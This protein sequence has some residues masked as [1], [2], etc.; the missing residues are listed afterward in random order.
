[1][2]KTRKEQDFSINLYHVMDFGAGPFEIKV[3]NGRGKITTNMQEFL[4]AGVKYLR[5]E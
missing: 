3:M 4:D 5:E 1:V 2:Q